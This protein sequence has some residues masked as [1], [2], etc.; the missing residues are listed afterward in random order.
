MSQIKQELIFWV[1]WTLFCFI[2]FKFLQIPK[3]W[4]ILAAFFILKIAEYI[5]RIKKSPSSTKQ[6]PE[7][8]M[9]TPKKTSSGVGLIAKIKAFF[10]PKKSGE[11]KTNAQLPGSD[12]KKVLKFTATKDFYKEKTS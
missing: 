9:T 8:K 4:V 11:T 7:P 10:F 1:L 6:T 5:Y 12:K 3:L 2:Q